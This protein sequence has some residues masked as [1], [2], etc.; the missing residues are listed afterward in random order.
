MNR[1]GNTRPWNVILNGRVI[2]TVWYTPNIDADSVRRS[3]INH[4]GYD[5]GITVLPG[6]K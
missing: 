2:D 5:A 6:A 3:L 4:D 1:N